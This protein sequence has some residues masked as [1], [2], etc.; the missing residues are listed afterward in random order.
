MPNP[1]ALLTPKQLEVINASVEQT[2]LEGY[3]IGGEDANFYEPRHSRTALFEELMVPG[4]A[5]KDSEA[6]QFVRDGYIECVQSLATIALIN[7]S[8]LLSEQGLAEVGAHLAQQVGSKIFAHEVVQGS[9]N[10]S[11]WLDVKNGQPIP[12]EV[13]HLLI[14]G[15]QAQ[16]R[17]AQDY[18][19][20][21]FGN[22]FGPTNSSSTEDASAIMT[23]TLGLDLMNESLKWQEAASVFN[24]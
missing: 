24:S 1:E 9:Y 10:I 20:M 23:S 15:E 12:R 11:Q 2:I 13:S 18:G 21:R 4:S 16:I 14:M 17:F 5:T 8:R 6:L 7:S 19:F 3:Q 22:D